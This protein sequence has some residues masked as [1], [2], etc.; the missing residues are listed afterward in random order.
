MKTIAFYFLF[1]F[2]AFNAYFSTALAT[3]TPVDTVLISDV[4]DTIKQANVQ[5]S[6]SVL[7]RARDDESRFLG[8]SEL[9]QLIGRMVPSIRYYYVSNAPERWMEK[10]H[11]RF[12]KNGNFP[13]G[14]YHPR[15]NWSSATHKLNTISRILLNQKPKH[16]I[17]FGDN[18]QHDAS[19]Y[20][21][22]TQKFANSGI[23]F[24]TFIR[25]VYAPGSKFY[26]SENKILE[27]TDPVQANQFA[28]VTP[29]EVSLELYRLGLVT[30]D[31][32]NWMI[33]NMIPFIVKE[34]DGQARGI[35]AFPDYVDCRGFQWPFAATKT[36]V[37]DQTQ[38]L[39]SEL[40]KKIQHR[41]S[42]AIKSIEL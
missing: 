15:N 24:H 35:L 39:L 38:L 21:A 9:Y 34:K 23:Q 7:L 5:S 26:N 19:I 33:A 12:L 36:L 41:C 11:L 4:D 6:I 25:I 42:M 10:V 32:P 40:Q 30:N 31:L 20:A 28:F 16:V 1:I 3:E 2:I 37:K 22:I 8:M 29:V 14:T 18:T 17:F 13:E 27:S